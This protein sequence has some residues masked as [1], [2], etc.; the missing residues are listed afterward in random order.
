MS[1][2]QSAP[3]IGVDIFKE[4]INDMKNELNTNLVNVNTKLDNITTRINYQDLKISD[5]GQRVESLEKHLTYA[6][7]AKT[8]PKLTAKTKSNTNTEN[9]TA[10]NTNQTVTENKNHNLTAEEIMNRSRNIVGI[11]PI[12]LEDIER[13]KCDTK[14]KTLINTATE[15]LKDELGFCQEHIEEMNITKVT[16]TKKKDGKTLYIKLPSHSSVT[17]YSSKEP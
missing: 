12:H 13:N 5:L 9:N 4:L 15:F 3:M 16:K 11:F 10:T 17:Q 7:A 6:E 8:P 14:K 2:S 1:G